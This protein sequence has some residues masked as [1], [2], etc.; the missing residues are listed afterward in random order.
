MKNSHHNITRQE[1]DIAPGGYSLFSVG[2]QARNFASALPVFE[3]AIAPEF[4]SSSSLASDIE[5]M[6]DPDVVLDDALYLNIAVKY[7]FA[8]VHDGAHQ[9][10]VA[11][12]DISFLYEQF[13]RHQSLNE[14]TDDIEVMNSMRQ[15]SSVLRVLADAPR[16]AHVMRAVV[17]QADL[18]RSWEGPFIGVD[19]GAGTGIMLLAQQVQAYRSGF[20]DIQT[21]GYQ[22]DPISG[23]RTHDL[24]HSL[25]MGSVM[26]ADATRKNAYGILRG[27]KVSH[28]ANEMVAGI[29]QS[30]CAENFFDKYKTFLSVVPTSEK[31]VFFPDGIIAHSGAD[32]SSLILVRENGYMVPQEYAD[33]V[34]TPQ[35]LIIEGAVLPMHKIG[36]DFYSFLIEERIIRE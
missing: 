12:K 20:D 2:M 29:Q 22:T 13:S 23:E 8:Y 1:K 26:L 31:T 10:K 3:S 19:I 28:V 7:F 33:A 9:E 14:P 25:G 34:F 5:K 18:H 6:C 36:Q 16:A 11:Y 21:Y 35:G 27:R 15:W 4:Y 30:L 17:G 32:G 24:I